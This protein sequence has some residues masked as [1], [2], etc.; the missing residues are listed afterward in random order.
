MNVNNAFVIVA[1][2]MFVIAA[3]LDGFGKPYARMF[4]SIGLAFW[5][6]SALV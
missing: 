3:A 1:V 5:A 2:I 6:A 4:M